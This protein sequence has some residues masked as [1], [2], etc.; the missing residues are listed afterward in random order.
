MPLPTIPHIAADYDT[1]HRLDMRLN[2]H[3][4]DVSGLIGQS[5]LPENMLELLTAF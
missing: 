5:L 2:Y 3:M 1:Y 4:F